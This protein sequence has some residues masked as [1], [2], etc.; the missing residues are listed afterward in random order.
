MLICWFG[1]ITAGT[2]EGVINVGVDETTAGA[3]GF[4]R[5]MSRLHSG[6]IQIYLGA[7]ALG[8]LA[9]VLFYVWLG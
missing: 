1:A 3:R 7:I 4:G 6:Q 9:L 2:D 5:V 8:M